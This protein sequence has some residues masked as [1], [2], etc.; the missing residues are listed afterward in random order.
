MGPA[1]A[2]AVYYAFDKSFLDAKAR[3]TLDKV[4]E[5]IKSSNVKSLT[6]EGNC[7]ERGTTEYNL[8]LGERRAESAK[9]YLVNLGID[10]AALQT[11]SFGK[12]K[13]VC[14]ESDESC[15]AKNRRSDVRPQAGVPRS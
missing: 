14:T 7:D 8:H 11:T 4:A 2:P 12:E 15:W 13:P 1:G 6:I 9:K 5:C 3:G 10:G